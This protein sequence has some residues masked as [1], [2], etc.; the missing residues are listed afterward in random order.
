MVFHIKLQISQYLME[1]H[2]LDKFNEL[3]SHR[4][5]DKK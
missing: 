1:M 3:T 5:V 4:L 2:S